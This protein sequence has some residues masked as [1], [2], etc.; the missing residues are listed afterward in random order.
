MNATG[1]ALLS[2]VWAT[3]RTRAPSEWSMCT[4]PGPLDKY[5]SRAV[6]ATGCWLECDDVT[7]MQRL[8]QSTTSPLLIDVGG[9]IGF[10][11]LAAARLRVVAR[12]GRW[13][14]GEREVLACSARRKVEQGGDRVAFGVVQLQF[15][16]RVNLYRRRFTHSL[17]P[18]RRSGPRRIRTRRWR[19]RRWVRSRRPATRR[20]A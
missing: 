8:L 19:A 18:T 15:Q 2:C 14:L 16:V 9:N 20:S 3:A 10:Y 13:R 6:Q 7:W 11:T 17:R 4:Y 12:R 1:D 5:V